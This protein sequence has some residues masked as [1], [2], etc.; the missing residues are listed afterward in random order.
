MAQRH[1]H[2]RNEDPRARYRV[3]LTVEKLREYGHVIRTKEN[4][5]DKIGVDEKRLKD[6]PKRRKLDMLDADLRGVHIF[7]SRDFW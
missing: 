1:D 4:L 3:A 5:L 2:F 7:L 6:R